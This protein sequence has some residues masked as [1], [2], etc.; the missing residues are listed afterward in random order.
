MLISVFANEIEELW[1]LAN[2]PECKKYL[3]L[4]TDK[5]I[6]MKKLRKLK[7]SKSPGSGGIHLRILHET[8]E[9]LMNVLMIIFNTSLTTDKLPRT[10][11]DGKISSIHKKGRSI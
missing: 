5:E 3:K 4:V 2:K 10:W 6:I 11:K 7:V 8:G 9:K 1:D